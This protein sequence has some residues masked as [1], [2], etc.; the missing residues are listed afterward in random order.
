MNKRS[1][2]KPKPKPNQTKTKTLINP[3]LLSSWDYSYVSLAL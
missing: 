3:Q 2:K 1:N